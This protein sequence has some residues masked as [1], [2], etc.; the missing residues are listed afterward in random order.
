[1]DRKN[2]ILLVVLTFLIIIAGTLSYYGST[3]KANITARSLMFDF[4][5][6]KIINNTESEFDNIDLYDSA[7]IHKGLGK[8]I[9][10][11][12]YGDFIIK[13]S[14]KGSEVKLR[15]DINLTGNDI[16]VNMK[17]Y[18]DSEKIDKVDINNLSLNGILDID[19]EREY[20][21][22]WEWPFDS[23]SDNKYDI[24]Y[25]DKT[26]TIDVN[27]SGK[28]TKDIEYAIKYVGFENSALYPSVI[29]KN[30]EITI[31]LSKYN[32]T[33]L[34][35]RQGNNDLSLDTHYTYNNGIL[36]LHNIIDNVT[37]TNLTSFC[38]MYNVNS[39]KDCLIATDYSNFR[40]DRSLVNAI[41]N[42][43]S[44]KADFTKTEPYMTYTENNSFHITDNN[45][46]TGSSLEQSYY[47][48][49]SMP[50]F[51]S[52]SGSRKLINGKSGTIE[53]IKNN[54]GYTCLH[55]WFD[56]TCTTIY[57]IYNY[58]V[59]N[60]SVVITDYDK[61]TFNLN[62]DYISKAGLYAIEDENN[63]KSYYYRGE[64]NNNWVSFG[65]FYWRIVRINGDGSIRLIYSG[66]KDNHSGSG[67]IIGNS[68]FNNKMHGSTYMGICI[69]M[70][71]W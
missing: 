42:I 25:Q 16:P 30:E 50:T 33:S 54:N 53:E 17:F 5:V 62:E 31:D 43:E 51:N 34:S 61:Y 6:F 35:L 38:S 71:I 4:N 69:M 21:I 15:Y 13:V 55:G 18:L 3:F 65:G 70:M 66:T 56:S 28:Q 40:K 68:S 24:E 27:I 12:D 67:T 9:V 10:P 64:V 20:T 39:L 52:A 48:T 11:G 22:Y 37:I 29:D 19:E 36:K 7:K 23:G 46:N 32:Y 8:V 60:N 44:K 59:V 45:Y 1:M 26:F 57:K 41:N 2:Y 47:Y 49:T 58:E 14:S 63:T